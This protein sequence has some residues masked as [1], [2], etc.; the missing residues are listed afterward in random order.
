MPQYLFFLA[1]FC[2]YRFILFALIFEE[3]LTTSAIWEQFRYR[4][5]SQLLLYQTLLIQ[6]N[7]IVHCNEPAVKRKGVMKEYL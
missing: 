4:K 3:A 7:E 6:G 1:T 2:T 5:S